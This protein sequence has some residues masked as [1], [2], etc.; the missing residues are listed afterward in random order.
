ML[1]SAVMR[2]VSVLFQLPEEALRLVLLGRGVMHKY[3]QAASEQT[4]T[5]DFMGVVRLFITTLQE[6]VRGSGTPL[7]VEIKKHS[8]WK[9]YMSKQHITS[10][11]ALKRALSLATSRASD[12][13][14]PKD[15]SKRLMRKKTQHS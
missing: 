7:S 2:L 6:Y 15:N 10:P 4:G 3:V 9:Q 14:V 12:I 13:V 11:K 8:L 5:P 1:L